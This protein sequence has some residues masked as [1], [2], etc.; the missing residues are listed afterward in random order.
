MSTR[1]AAL[2][3][4]IPMRKGHNENA[5]KSTYISSFACAN[6]HIHM[7]AIAKAERTLKKKIKLRHLLVFH[8][9]Q[10]AIPNQ[11]NKLMNM[12]A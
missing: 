1:H 4:G 10:L 9:H 2:L 11:K 6:Q 7:P 12:C 3:F 8:G 5:S